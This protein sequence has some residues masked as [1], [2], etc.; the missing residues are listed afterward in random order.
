LDVLRRHVLRL[1]RQNRRPQPRVAVG[2][3]PAA[4][5]RN[6]N[7]L[8]QAREDLAPL[9]VG[10]A[11]LMLD[12]RPLRMAG[13][14]FPRNSRF[15]KLAGLTRRSGRK[16]QP[17]ASLTQRPILARQQQQGAP[18]SARSLIARQSGVSFAVANERVPHSSRALCA[19]SG[20]RAKPNPEGA[21]AFRPLKQSATKGA[22]APGM[23]SFR[24]PPVRLLESEARF[25][26]TQSW[27]HP[28][29]LL[30]TPQSQ[31]VE[32]NRRHP[33]CNA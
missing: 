30:L 3:A 5:G 33:S 17:I 29:T 23:P 11:L 24:P 8:D 32:S 28:P 12:G 9:G 19:M 1:G 18:S 27:P 14:V 16:P 4:L 10:R 26:T 20:Y 22:S 31:T 7:F 25:I 2:I 13:H 6:R 15:C 21:G